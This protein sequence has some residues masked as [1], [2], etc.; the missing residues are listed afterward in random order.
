MVGRN[1][2]E[3]YKMA[4]L[5]KPIYSPSDVMGILHAACVRYLD[6]IGTLEDNTPAWHDLDKISAQGTKC[7]GGGHGDVRQISMQADANVVLV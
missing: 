1:G 4:A 7:C 6:F 5:K 2:R 3:E